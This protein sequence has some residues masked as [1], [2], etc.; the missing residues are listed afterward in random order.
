MNRSV[1]RRVRGGS[2]INDVKTCRSRVRGCSYPDPVFHDCSVFGFRIVAPMP[3]AKL[4]T[5]QREIDNIF[6]GP[7]RDFAICNDGTVWML[8]HGDN[9]WRRIP[10]I[11]QD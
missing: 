1:W 11:P 3:V 5:S 9:A 6:S 7:L 8:D 4:P 2:D 10:P